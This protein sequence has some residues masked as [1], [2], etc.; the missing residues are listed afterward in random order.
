MEKL[1]FWFANLKHGPAIVAILFS[2][3]IPIAIAV[4]GNAG[5]AGPDMKAV[6]GRLDLNLPFWI[7]SAQLLLLIIL[8]LDL[9]KDFVQFI[10]SILPGKNWLIALFIL[11]AI[12]TWATGT[13]VEGRHR[14]QSDE[15]IFLSTAQNLYSQQVSGA[16]DEGTFSADG[17]DCTKNANN[18]KA[19]G[20]A[21]LIMVGIPLLGNNLQW[22]FP[23][24]LL[25]YFVTGILFFFALFAW[26]K[27]HLLSL[28]ATVILLVQPT[29]MF[30]FRAMSVEPLYI[31]L[32]ALALLWM[33]WA[34]ERDT[35]RHWVILALTLAFFAQT[36]QETAFCLGAF[37]LFSVPKLLSK[38]DLRFPAFISTLALFSIPI[39][40]TISYYQG[41]DFQGGE[42]SAHGNF[43]KNVSTNWD[44]MAKTALD[45]SGLLVNP[46]L[47]S[48]TWLG[49][50]GLVTLLVL[51]FQNKEARMW[52]GFL[53]LYHIQTYMILEN[54]SGDFTIEINQRYSLVFFP[55]LAFLSAFFLERIWTLWIEKWM[56]IRQE[57]KG[58]TTLWVGIGV[59][60]VLMGITF[61]HADSFKANIM[62]NRN[63]LTSEE[64]EILKW[65]R[66]Q[67]E[68]PRIFI[69]AR[70]WHFIAY[71]YSSWHYDRVRGLGGGELDALIQK[72][73]GE[74]YYVRGLDCWDRQT[75]HK[76]AV[77]RRIASTCDDFERNFE[78]EPV[79]TT[80]ITNN[81]ELEISKL[82]GTKDYDLASISALGIF[83]YL[84]KENQVL[85]SYRLSELSPK[86]WTYQLWLNDS[87]W[88]NQP[89]QAL[90]IMDTLRK[91]N[92]VAG[93]NSIRLAIVDAN[94]TE[95]VSSQQTAFF[96]Q[97]RAVQLIRQKPT[98]ASQSWG[99]MQINQTVNSNPLQV[100]GRRFSEGFGTHAFSRIEFPLGGKYQRFTA[101]VGQDDEELGGD[102]M[103]FRILGDGKLLWSSP[104]LTAKQI[105][106]V[107]ISIQGIQNLAL[108][109]DSLG[110]NF[111]DHADWLHPTLYP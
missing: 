35:V 70:P 7:F 95:L 82:K 68:K 108:E 110:N 76:K 12:A 59:A 97:G 18:F 54:V 81:F 8:M 71:G 14:V 15:S 52:V 19:R 100:G 85:V 72:Y 29:V 75:W 66:S 31:T 56:G 20:F 34:F 104:T 17:L 98:Q 28:L 5:I 43:W 79:F 30:Q 65:V 6:L 27:N 58:K 99:T 69:Y 80:M 111:Y 32:S 107:D 101:L 64:Y 51:A 92:I 74:V 60:I 39:L 11:V 47:T 37:I 1:K 83:N 41:Y 73:Q 63:H 57:A 25:L 103:V 67:P 105:S 38:K 22:L 49:L 26:T 109:V 86:P 13:W 24:H 33:K 90:A 36:R 53:A 62:Y 44:V 3:L 96:S 77:E 94:G 48:S 4:A 2:M 21:Y 10:K 61:R 78:V 106:P 50:F 91:P 87:L 89:Y 102:G 23:M 46:F 88:R 84:E 93:Y 40:L 42:F 16:C 45:P 9:A 55:T